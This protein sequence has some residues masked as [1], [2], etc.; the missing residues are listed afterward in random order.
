MEANKREIYISR[1]VETTFRI[2]QKKI[3][4]YSDCLACELVVS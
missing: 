1:V 3:S 2:E 4:N